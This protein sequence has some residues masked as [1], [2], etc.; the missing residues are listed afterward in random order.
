MAGSPAGVGA[1]ASGP[2]AGAGRRQP[3]HLGALPTERRRLLGRDE[4]QPDFLAQRQPALHHGDLFQDGH[5]N[6][7]VLLP[8]CGRRR[9]AFGGFAPDRDAFDLGALGAEHLARQP[10][11]DA[12]GHGDAHAADLTR[13]L[14][15]RSVSSTRG[16][17]ARPSRSSSASIVAAAAFIRTA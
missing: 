11:F 14:P 6:R 8:P 16:S 10:L 7:A 5:N 12:R 2:R 13:R 15:T 4:P 17:T 1:A 9:L 3:L